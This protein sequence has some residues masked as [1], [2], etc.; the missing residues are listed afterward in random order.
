M[1]GFHVGFASRSD[2]V[3]APSGVEVDNLEQLGVTKPLQAVPAGLDS[4]WFTEAA[5]RSPD[6]KRR[7][8]GLGG[9]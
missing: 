9:A 2:L 6:G 4:A 3:L 1:Q 8:I 5:D 7:T